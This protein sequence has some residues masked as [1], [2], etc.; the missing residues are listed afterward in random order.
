MG[1][2]LYLVI[3]AIFHPFMVSG[4]SME[5]SLH[6]NDVVICY[7]SFNKGDLKRGDIIIYKQGNKNVIK[8][9]VALPGDSVHVSNGYLYVNGLLSPFNYEKMDDAG[10]LSDVVTLGD[11]EFIYLGDNRNQSVD[12]RK[13][14][15]GNISDL[16]Y[17]VKKKLFEN[18]K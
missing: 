6:N 12:S 4:P 5:P 11:D 14:G 8:R 16:K 13:Y 7:T 10:I 9:V 17:L 15:V 2:A 18:R 1:I 3:F